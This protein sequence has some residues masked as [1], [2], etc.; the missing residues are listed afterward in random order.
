LAIDG[1]LRTWDREGDADPDAATQGML[2]G[3]V[4]RDPALL[5]PS[6]EV[7]QLV[8]PFPNVPGEAFGQ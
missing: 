2:P 7:P 8:G 5:D 1:D 3:A 4:H 6:E